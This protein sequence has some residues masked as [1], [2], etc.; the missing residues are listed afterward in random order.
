M[1]FLE[2]SLQKMLNVGLDALQL[3][4]GVR[5]KKALEKQCDSQRA[6]CSLPRFSDILVQINCGQ[7]LFFL[8][9]AAR[10]M[11]LYAYTLDSSIVIQDKK[12]KR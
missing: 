6:G 10:N 5:K 11:Q 9:L 1:C 7:R 3:A 8:L 4:C 12:V 2:I